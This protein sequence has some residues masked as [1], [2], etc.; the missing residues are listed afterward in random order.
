M[1]RTVWLA[2]SHDLTM[3]APRAIAEGCAQKTAVA[4]QGRGGLTIR[5]ARRAS[6]EGSMLTLKRMVSLV[7]VTGLLI[8]AQAASANAESTGGWSEWNS[9]FGGGAAT[10]L[11]GDVTG[12]HQSDAVAFYPA[13]GQA[14][15]SRSNG[16]SFVGS[17]EWT[18]GECINSTK[19][20]L[21]DVN[22][23]G[24][25]DLVCFY[26][27]TNRWWVAWSNG[28]Q[29]LN[30]TLWA[31]WGGGCNNELMA[32]VTGDGRADILCYTSNGL[33][34]VDPSTGGSFSGGSLWN[35]QGGAECAN[36]NAQFL[37]DVN[38]DGKADMACYYANSGQWWVG[39][40]NGSGF[41]WVSDWNTNFG[42]GSSNQMLADVS[43]DGR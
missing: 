6:G 15:V 24:K 36:S 9:S 37:A 23:D 4:S 42:T 39:W 30:E 32:D 27:S 38:G 25:A 7:G 33:W 26:A 34:W 2:G 29:F 40:S 10:R 13:T 16:S 43:G 19:Q 3:A 21:A 28:S 41:L 18:S 12:D 8:V 35:Y 11:G 1:H 5:L 17:E 22:G 31:T 14:W 20:F